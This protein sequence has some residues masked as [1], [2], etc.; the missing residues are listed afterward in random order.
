MFDIG[1]YIMRLFE[2]FES[3]SEVYIGDDMDDDDHDVYDLSNQADELSR[4]SSINI[5]RDKE[6]SMVLVDDGSDEVVGGLW[7]SFDG[8][9]YS[10][11]VIVA[12]R[13][14]NSGL[15]HRLISAG[16]DEYRNY[17]MDMDVGLNLHVTNPFLPKVLQDKYGLKVKEKHPDGTVS[18]ST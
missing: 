10:F 15:G 18:M 6:L 14:R 1:V 5:L 4:K 3:F 13:F 7:T 16:M 9:E 12:D 11:D 17:A 8:D 2:L